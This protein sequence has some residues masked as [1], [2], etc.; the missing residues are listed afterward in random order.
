[1]GE[2]AKKWAVKKIELTYKLS[3]KFFS[4]LGKSKSVTIGQ[5]EH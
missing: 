2:T 1:M 4:E 5:T 3:D